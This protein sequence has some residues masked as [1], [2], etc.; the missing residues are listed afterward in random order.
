MKRILL[1]EDIRPLSE[2]R[3][4]VASYIDKVKKTK[5]PL[6]ITQ[7]GKSAAVVLDV[8]EYETL[9]EK[10]ELLLDIQI[11][12]QQIENGQGINHDEAKNRILGI[13]A[14]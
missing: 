3:A 14:K 4:N 11:A 5:R 13:I 7:R 10:L 12:E 9:I 2:F 1:S 6:V 8:A